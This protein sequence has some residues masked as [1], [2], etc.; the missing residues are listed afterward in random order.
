MFST[1]GLALAPEVTPGE[2][3]PTRK[4]VAVMQGHEEWPSLSPKQCVSGDR[5]SGGSLV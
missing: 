5:S 4:A 1:L 2:G 3:H